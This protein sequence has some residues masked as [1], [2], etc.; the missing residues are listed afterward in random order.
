MDYGVGIVLHKETGEAV[1]EGDVLATLYV[2]D[3]SK[4]AQVREM[5]HDAIVIQDAAPQKKPTIY[6]IIE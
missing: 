5:V 4:A 3:V 6:A 1:A 2:N